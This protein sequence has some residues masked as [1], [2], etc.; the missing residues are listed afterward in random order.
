M[1]QQHEKCED[2]GQKDTTLPHI[3]GMT[4]SY[5]GKRRNSFLHDGFRRLLN[6]RHLCVNLLIWNERS[7]EK[8]SATTNDIGHN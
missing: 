7:F 2:K 6:A 5:S 3:T 1:L 4:L 8:I